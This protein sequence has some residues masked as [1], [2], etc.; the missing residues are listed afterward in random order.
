MRDQKL[1]LFLLLS[2]VPAFAWSR[3]GA[4]GGL[5]WWLQVSPIIVA[6]LVLLVTY[7]W[8]R[9]TPLAYMLIWIYAIVLLFGA[10]YNY[11]DPFFNWLKQGLHLK[12]NDFDRLTHFLQGFRSPPAP[13]I[14]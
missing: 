3:Y 11:A 13:R 9:L 4:K 14:P 8:F 5:D 10:H 6:L 2:L 7:W 12:R 1:H